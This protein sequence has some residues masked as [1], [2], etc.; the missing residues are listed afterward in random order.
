MCFASLT[1]TSAKEDFEFT[2]DGNDVREADDVVCYNE[3]E[4]EH[5]SRVVA[6]KVFF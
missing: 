6:E 1:A 4:I 3:H 2:E 5:I